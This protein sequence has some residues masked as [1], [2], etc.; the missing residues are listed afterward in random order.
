MS[1]RQDKAGCGI[2]PHEASFS[3]PPPAEIEKMARRRF[4]S[5]TPFREGCFWWLFHWEDEFANGKRIRKRKRTKLA[6]A[7]LSEREVKKIAAEFLRPLNQGL[8]TVGSA[9]SSPSTWK[10]CTRTQCFR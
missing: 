1:L 6:P 2:V 8:V 3:T 5:P 4:Q 7:T 10:R 9:I